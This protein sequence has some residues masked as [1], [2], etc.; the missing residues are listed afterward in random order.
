[1][2]IDRKIDWL[3]ITLVTKRDWRDFLPFRTLKSDGKG[4]HGYGERW[5]DKE[6]HAQIE[7]A[8][9][10][11]DMGVHFTLTGDVL[12]ALRQEFEMTDDDMVKHMVAWGAKCSRVDLAI[13]CFGSDFTPKDLSEALNNGDAKITA[14]EWRFIEGHKAKLR[15]DTVDTGSPKS[16]KRFRFYDKRAESKIQDGDAWVRLEIQLR[17]MYARAAIA[18][19][20]ESTVSATASGSIGTFLRWSNDNYRTA[21]VGDASNLPPLPRKETNRRKWLLGQVAQ[22]L[23]K[24]LSVDPDFRNKFDI[25]V[26]FFLEMLSVDGNK[27]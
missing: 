12:E 1:V 10:R 21:L 7:T 22:A 5:T 3:S 2:E 26:G 16:D 6:T 24:E 4:R 18:T 19:C 27:T 25:S 20:A 11:E 23:A 17:R 14:R 8:S 9:N 15:G 13:D